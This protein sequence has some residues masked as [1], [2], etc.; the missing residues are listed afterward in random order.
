MKKRTKILIALPIILGIL[1]FSAYKFA[2]KAKGQ[3][4]IN[5]GLG[6]IKQRLGLDV[7][8]ENEVIGKNT[9]KTFTGEITLDKNIK[10]FEEIGTS[11]GDLAKGNNAV[12]YTHLTL[13][14]TSR[15]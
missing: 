8:L 11:L 10:G 5:V 7:S 1:G 9:H 4:N 3:D 6:L 2:V 12:S 14:T 15:V 13:P